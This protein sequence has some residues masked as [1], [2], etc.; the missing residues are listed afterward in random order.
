MTSV[1]VLIANENEKVKE[2]I[3]IPSDE[4]NVEFGIRNALFEIYGAANVCSS[5]REI[6]PV[7]L[8][9][10]GAKDESA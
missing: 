5:N 1:Y 4:K 8:I 10:N 2:C 9:R 6:G 3:V 7:M